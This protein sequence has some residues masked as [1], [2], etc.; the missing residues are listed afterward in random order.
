MLINSINEYF[1]S[2]REKCPWF[3]I[4]INVCM[5]QQ[6]YH[7]YKEC[8]Q[9]NCPMFFWITNV[10]LVL[11]TINKGEQPVYRASTNKHCDVCGR[12]DELFGGRCFFCIAFDVDHR[13]SYIE[14]IDVILRDSPFAAETK[15]CICCGEPDIAMRCSKCEVAVCYDCSKCDE[16]TGEPVCQKCH[17]K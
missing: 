3:G 11:A 13:V 10:L 15:T 5:G 6:E 12:F 7:E 17:T 9:E 1:L 8:V 14:A 16:R 2:N 4:N